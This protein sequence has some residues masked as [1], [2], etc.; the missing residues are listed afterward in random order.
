[1][2][3][4]VTFSSK[5]KTT[6]LLS[7]KIHTELEITPQ[8]NLNILGI[9]SWN[10]I[11]TEIFLITPKN[12]NLPKNPEELSFLAKI[13]TEKTISLLNRVYYL[14]QNICIYE[15]KLKDRIEQGSFVL[16]VGLKQKNNYPNFIKN[17][18]KNIYDV[19]LENL[20]ADNKQHI[21]IISSNTSRSYSAAMQLKE[22]GFNAQFFILDPQE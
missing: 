21:I 22:L 13:S 18:Y 17:I 16:E 19:N 1:L 2:G 8:T 4:K 5:A 15:S 9:Y 10:V 11:F 6:L 3:A 12:N 7:N 20:F 14:N